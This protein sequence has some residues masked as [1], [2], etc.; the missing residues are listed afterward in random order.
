MNA[1]F[2]FHYCKVANAVRCNLLTLNKPYSV[3]QLQQLFNLTS[4]KVNENCEKCCNAVRWYMNLLYVNILY[5][6]VYI[7]LCCNLL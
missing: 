2:N 4:K 1:R 3:Q 5:L 6:T 7:F